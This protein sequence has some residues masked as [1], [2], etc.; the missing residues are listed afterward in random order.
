PTVFSVMHNVAVPYGITT[1]DKPH[2]S[3]TQW[4]SV[5]DQKNKIYYFQPTLAMQV[6]WVDLTQVDFSKGTPERV[7]QMAGNPKVFVGDVTAQF[8]PAAKPFQFLL[9]V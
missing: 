5:S 6:F 4:I 8:K 7:L 3:A 2:I 1:P 9:E